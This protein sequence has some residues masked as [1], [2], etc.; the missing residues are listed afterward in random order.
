MQNWLILDKTK[1]DQK[2]QRLHSIEI[3]S[4]EKIHNP[5][6]IRL[7]EVEETLSNNHMVM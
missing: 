1:I 6:I 2:T 5:N 3:N 4:I 7:Y